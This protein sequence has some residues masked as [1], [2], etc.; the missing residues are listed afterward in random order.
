MT[1]EILSVTQGDYRFKYD[2]TKSIRV[3]TMNVIVGVPSCF[4]CLPVMRKLVVSTPLTVT[5][6]CTATS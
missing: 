6:V 4:M 3:L 5:V 2:L 1:L